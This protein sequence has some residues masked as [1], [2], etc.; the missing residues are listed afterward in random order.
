VS[1]A[2]VGRRATLCFAVEVLTCVQASFLL[3]RSHLS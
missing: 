2:A 3:F 1:F